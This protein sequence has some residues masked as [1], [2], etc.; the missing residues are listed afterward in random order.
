MEIYKDPEQDIIFA[1]YFSKQIDI[2]KSKG[3]L[4]CYESLVGK[5]REFVE[6][7]Y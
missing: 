2:K 4:D 1:Q 7:L 5:L 6:N 3:L